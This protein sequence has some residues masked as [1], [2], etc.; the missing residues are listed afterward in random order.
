MALKEGRDPSGSKFNT[1]L[2]KTTAIL[3][4]GAAALTGC[5]GNNTEAGSPSSSSMATSTEQPTSQSTLEDQMDAI[6]SAMATPTPKSGA[7]A[8]TTAKPEAKPPHEW[9][10]VAEVRGALEAAKTNAEKRT[11]LIDFIEANSP[12]D[13]PTIGEEDGSFTPNPESVEH[14]K[15]HIM[16][17]MLNVLV[18]SNF[19]LNRSDAVS[20]DDRQYIVNEFLE[21]FTYPGRGRDYL[22]NNIN[23]VRDPGLFDVTIHN[24]DD[25]FNYDVIEGMP[26]I[27]A[28][29]SGRPG[30]GTHAYLENSDH[31][32]P[33]W[34]NSPTQGA[35][36]LAEF[37]RFDDPRYRE[38]NPKKY[39]FI[40]M[41]VDSPVTLGGV[42]M[43][44]DV[45]EATTMNVDGA[46]DFMTI[47][48]ERV[49]LYDIPGY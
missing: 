36:V 38:G 15:E 29:S 32:S 39:T 24:P 21:Q 17:A 33:Q 3:T 43:L 44:V 31:A 8:S 47:E 22:S 16:Q 26:A 49:S 1:L 46:A 19:A 2:S 12:I 5:A 30:V 4:I 13:Y 34:I 27:I 35:E 23:N 42:L 40:L 11:A 20:D 48:G 25:R 10:G 37:Y 9:V 7:E 41:P 6:A 28:I 18:M 45:Q 14:A